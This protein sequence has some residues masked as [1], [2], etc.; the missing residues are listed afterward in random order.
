MC[1]VPSHQ[2]PRARNAGRRRK[3]AKEL[4]SGKRFLKACQK[5]LGTIRAGAGSTYG[6]KVHDDIDHCEQQMDKLRE[7]VKEL[8][9]AELRIVTIA[10]RATELQI[11]ITAYTG[12]L[13]HTKA[14]GQP[15]SALVTLIQNGSC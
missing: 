4:A 2:T 1:A 6:N 13:P 15:R 12:M 3:I 10:N 7:E 8:D 14:G 5:N 9:A 11:L